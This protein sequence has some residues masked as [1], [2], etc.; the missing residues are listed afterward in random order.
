MTDKRL[1]ILSHPQARQNAV[2][3]VKQAPEGWRVTIA[4][5]RKSRAQEEKYHA[6]IGDISRQYTHAGR[7]WDEE[8][9]KRL[10]VAA[11]KDDTKDDE[12]LAEC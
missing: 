7:K 4:P 9:M 5:P 1:F 3:A 6:Q 10:L 11:F 2:V 8:N 12:D